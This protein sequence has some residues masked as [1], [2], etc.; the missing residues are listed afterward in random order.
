VAEAV[1][2]AVSTVEAA[3]PTA[4]ELPAAFSVRNRL[5]IQKGTGT[6]KSRMDFSVPVPFLWLRPIKMMR[7]L[8]FFF[9]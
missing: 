2:L 3:R 6:E 1:D 4:A 5:V 8:F 9:L 7:I